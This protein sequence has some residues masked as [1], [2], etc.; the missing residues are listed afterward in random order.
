MSRKRLSVP[1]QKE[2]PGS[3]STNDKWKMSNDKWKISYSLIE[4]ADSAVY[5][6]SLGVRMDKTLQEATQWDGMAM[7]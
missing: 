1:I 5:Y 2:L 3:K 7:I 6:P 4:S